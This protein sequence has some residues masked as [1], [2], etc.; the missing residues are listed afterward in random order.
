[1]TSR[2]AICLMG[3]LVFGFGSAHA[4]TVG[5]K[6]NLNH[7]ELFDGARL[8]PKAIEGRVTLVYFWA[9]WCPICRK[10]M[11]AIE[12]H[13]QNFKERGFMVVAVNFRDK[14][15]AAR[16]F[17]EAMKPISYMVGSINDN[18][19]SD[20]PNLKAT[21]TWMLIDKKGVIRTV[22]VGKEVISG[23]WFD[24]LE[25]DLKKVIAE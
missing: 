8:D 1:M 4:Q 24:G 11:P 23:G 18:W 12:K 10:E 25:G 6:A 9:S 13:Y 16:D 14:P 20:Y 22:I 5:E 17:V 15:Q 21:P 7:V 2:I 19:M 3:I